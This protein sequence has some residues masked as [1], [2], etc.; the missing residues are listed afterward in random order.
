MLKLAQKK[1]FLLSYSTITNE[2]GIQGDYINTSH[3]DERVKPL[4]SMAKKKLENLSLT[5]WTAWRDYSGKCHVK[6]TLMTTKMMMKLT[7][8]L[9]FRPQSY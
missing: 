8:N 9:L 6:E 4:K 1:Q 3:P 5:D 7:G 2:K